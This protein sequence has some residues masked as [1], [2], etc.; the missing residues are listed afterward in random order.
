MLL[1]P[2]PNFSRTAPAVLSIVCILI[3][4]A[5]AAEPEQVKLIAE[6]KATAVI[7]VP[8]R[9]WDNPAKSPEATQ[10]WRKVATPED[11]RRRLRESVRDFAAILQ[12]ISGAAVEL[13]IGPPAADDKRLPI[14][15]GELAVA[16]FGKA[17]KSYR[18]SQG[19]RIVTTRDAVG[20]IGESDLAC[21]YALYTI[22][23]DL[24]CRWFIPGELG[25]VLPK[26]ATVALPLQDVSTGPYTHYRAVWYADNDYAR[27][28]RLG[29]LVLSAVHALEYTL[30]KATREQYPE[31]RAIIKGKPHPEKVKWTHP[32]VT[33]SLVEVLRARLKKDPATPSFSLSPVDGIGWDEEYDPQYDAKDFDPSTSIVSK[34]D[35]LMVMANRVAAEIAKDHPEVLFGILAYVDYTRPPVR[36]KVHRNVVPQIAPITYSRAHPM[37]EEGEPNNAD[38]RRIVEG[39]GKA[40]EMTS[41]YFYGWFLAELSAPNPMIKKWSVD[42]PI[43]YQ[44]GACRFWQ[45]ETITNFE[46]SM[47]ALYLGSRLAW[48]PQQQP[49]EIID[50]LHQ[51]FYGTAS[52]KMAAYWHYVDEVWTGVPEYSG[53]GWGHLRRFTPER[54]TEMRALLNAGK[55]AAKNDIERERIQMADDSL[56]L[57]ELFMKLRHDLAEGRFANLARDAATYAMRMNETATKYA[58]QYAFGKV[59]YGEPANINLQYFNSFYKA[60]Y[61]DATRIATQHTLV[62]PAIRQFRYRADKEARGEGAAWQAPDHDDKDWA[63]TDVG[64]ETWSSLGLHNYMGKLWY[65]TEIDVPQ[66][67]AEQRVFLWVGATD[68][69]AKVFV[70]GVHIPYVDEK[71]MASDVFRGY[72]TPASFEITD[73]VR[74]GKRNTIAILC[75]REFLNELGSGGLLAPIVLY[76]SK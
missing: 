45:P 75:H 55:A 5:H 24:G 39:W 3:L 38:L 59:P 1:Y 44:K 51:K 9:L 72:A 61:D 47:H 56:A 43:V 40:V 57:F 14:L 15:V 28:N 32:Q 30:P 53:C 13:H 16:R 37:T 11:Q 34:T 27:R 12:R 65:R 4:G 74:R 18:Y 63:S 36:E 8:Q 41:Y 33:D 58:K 2:R 21:S 73:A 23:H 52:A 50:E 49:A 70:N 35:R 17:Q 19:F 10:S 68:G 6:G 25:E 54:M 7:C 64:T 66:L 62:S 26:S 71:K 69:S 20:I 42:I 67:N 22:L 31:I 76:T 29:G 48:D 60:T 46:S